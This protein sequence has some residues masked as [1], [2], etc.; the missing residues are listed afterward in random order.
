MAASDKPNCKQSGSNSQQQNHP[1]KPKKQ[2]PQQKI[3]E[4]VWP[5]II[6]DAPGEDSLEK[7]NSCP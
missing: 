7:V 5:P 1:N 3:I 2:K 4:D 6:T